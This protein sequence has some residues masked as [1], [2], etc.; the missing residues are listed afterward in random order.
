MKKN[1]KSIKNKKDFSVSVVIP[2]YNNG[3]V[4][5]KPLEEAYSILKSTHMSFEM[6]ILN[7]GSTDNTE[8]V[9][10]HFAKNRKEVTVLA[11]TKNKGIA[12]TVQELY[13]AA[14]KQYIVLF[15]VDGGWEPRDILRL[16]HAIEKNNTDIVIGE[17]KGKKYTFF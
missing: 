5:K 8:T 16:I 10:N 3:A 7:D 1:K 6:I 13:A 9:V 12:K 15:S 14:K 2:N 17:R 11:H 4:C